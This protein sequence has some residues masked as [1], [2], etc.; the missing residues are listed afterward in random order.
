MPYSQQSKTKRRSGEKHYEQKARE[1]KVKDIEAAGD[2]RIN[3]GSLAGLAKKSQ[4]ETQAEAVESAKPKN[5]SGSSS[6]SASKPKR[7]DYAKGLA[8]D[9][10]YQK[11]LRAYRK[12]DK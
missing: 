11:A 9:A 2:S 12:K 6:S 1:K 7:S 10:A 4:S 8:G 5:G 3:K